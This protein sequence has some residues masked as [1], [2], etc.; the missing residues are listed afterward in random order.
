VDKVLFPQWKE[1]LSGSEEEKIAFYRLSI[2]WLFSQE[3]IDQRRIQQN[4]AALSRLCIHHRLL[5]EKINQF[6]EDPMSLK[7]PCDEIGNWIKNPKRKH[8]QLSS[9]RA[10]HID[11]RR[12]REE[13]R[14]Q[15]LRQ[16]VQPW[17]G[18]KV[19]ASELDENDLDKIGMSISSDGILEFN[20]RMKKSKYRVV[21]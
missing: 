19:N 7:N 12:Q 14:L 17:I 18:K 9:P 4:I 5:F 8:K 3:N 13:R 20:K 6:K 2:C 15:E 11:R 21:D 10:S 16:R 1:K